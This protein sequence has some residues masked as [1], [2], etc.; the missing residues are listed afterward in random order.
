VG[1]RAD[2]VELD[3]ELKVRRVMREGAWIVDQRA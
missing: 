2:L 1:R 3:G